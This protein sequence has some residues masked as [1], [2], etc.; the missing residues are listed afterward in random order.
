MKKTCSLKCSKEHKAVDNCDGK[1]HD[2]T[3][4]IPKKSIQDADDEKHEANLLV[5][6]D[7]NFLTNI[8][9][10]VELKRRDGLIK[11]KRT[12]QDGHQNNMNNK[13]PRQVEQ[14]C[15]RII[16][17]GVN[18][19]VLPRGMQRSMTN[20]SKWDKPLDLFVWSIE[21]IIFAPKS[22]PAEK[23][24]HVSHRIKETDT[25]IES[26]GKVI[27]DKCC[28][29]YKLH[30]EEDSS[31]ETKQQR[32]QILITSG[33]K[34]Y[35]K[36]FPY[37]TTEILDSKKLVALESAKSIAE[38]FRNRTVI[39]FPTI[40]V[41]KEESDLPSEY[42]IVD[43]N[44]LIEKKQGVMPQRNVSESDSQTDDEPVE[45]SSKPVPHEI[46]ISQAPDTLQVNL[47]VKVVP[48]YDSD[49]DG[50][51]PGVTMDFLAD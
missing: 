7:Y 39:E 44:A 27:Y 32:T 21:W 38:L 45:E 16:R 14:E 41:V 2:P 30:I 31:T 47:P 40:F 18:C 5:Q 49:S 29:Y 43:E 15:P 19:L 23:F 11:N 42:S 36:W 50:Y 12:L 4:Y 24:C 10:A 35:A 13:R 8:K 9:R 6:R 34:F 28:D 22:Q 20:K 48:N 33:L 3:T 25:L 51:D 26:M 46:P 1:S 37:N 17:R